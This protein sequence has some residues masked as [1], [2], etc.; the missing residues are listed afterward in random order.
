[1]S[2]ALNNWAVHS[3][4]GLI[5]LSGSLAFAIVAADAENPTLPPPAQERVDFEKEVKPIFAAHCIKCH[6]PE[7]QK[8]EFRLDRRESALKGGENHAPDIRPGHSA[9]SPLIR[10]VSGA[11]PDMKMPQK[12]EP[13]TVE[14]IGLLRAWIDQGANW[15]EN[16][17]VAEE[18]HWSLKPVSRPSIPPSANRKWQQRNAIDA[19]ILA[20]LSD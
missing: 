14:E 12:G 18:K 15:P 10:F 11:V 2:S 16:A 9:E 1:M 8:G 5:A 4:T 6:G 3:L 17:R 19:F 7:K 13:L 20:K